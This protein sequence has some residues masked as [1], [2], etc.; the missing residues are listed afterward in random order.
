MKR[1]I[2]IISIMFAIILFSSCN[3]FGCK[4][5]GSECTGVVCGICSTGDFDVDQV[6]FVYKKD[7][8]ASAYVVRH[9]DETITVEIK[10][11]LKDFDYLNVAGD[12]YV[13]QNGH[14]IARNTFSKYVSK[15]IGTSFEVPCGIINK[16]ITINNN[17]AIVVLDYVSASKSK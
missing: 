7:F 16:G 4:G 6:S 3:F 8:D 5:C 11:D 1:S 17:S 10:I 9:N 12:I 15:E 14:V 2:V 13:L